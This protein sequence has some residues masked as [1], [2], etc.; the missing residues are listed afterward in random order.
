MGSKHDFFVTMQDVRTEAEIDLMK[1]NTAKA[2]AE[3]RK[4]NREYGVIPMTIGATLM[5]AATGLAA[6]IL[7]FIGV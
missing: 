2:L 4:I 3:A 6:L 5:A 1:A 7:K